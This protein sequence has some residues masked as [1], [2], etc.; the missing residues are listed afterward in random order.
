MSCLG[1]HLLLAFR[2]PTFDGRTKIHCIVLGQRAV[3]KKLLRV[4]LDRIS[5]I[6]R[7][8]SRHVF[9]LV[10][11][12]G[13]VHCGYEVEGS[14]LTGRFLFVGTKSIQKELK[15]VNFEGCTKFC[16]DLW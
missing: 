9:H 10:W 2:I 14:G 8:D 1:P 15:I 3:E 12:R 6:L 4:D 5:K 13:G 11:L 7:L 16:D